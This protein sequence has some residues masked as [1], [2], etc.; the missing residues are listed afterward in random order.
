MALIGRGEAVRCGVGEV[1]K[2]HL[3]D[4]V[5]RPCQTHT[6]LHVGACSVPLLQIPLALFAPAE[7]DRSHRYDRLATGG[8]DNALAW[9][10]HSV[11][12]FGGWGELTSARTAISV[13]LGIVAAYPIYSLVSRLAELQAKA[14]KGESRK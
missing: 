1:G 3:H 13:I 5:V 7:P 10:P 14:N 2:Q 12:N 11:G 9:L 6:K 8:I 4:I